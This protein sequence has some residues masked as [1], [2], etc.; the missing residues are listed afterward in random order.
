MALW[1]SQYLFYFLIRYVLDQGLLSERIRGT[2]DSMGRATQVTFYVKC[3]FGKLP[4]RNQLKNVL[5]TNYLN[6]PY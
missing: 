5:K 2:M 1:L 6:V 3:S 4:F